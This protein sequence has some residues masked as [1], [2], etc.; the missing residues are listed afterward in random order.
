MPAPIPLHNPCTAAHLHSGADDVVVG[1]LGSE[2]VPAG[3]TVGSQNQG[4]LILWVKQLLD[5]AGPQPPSRS[6]LG[7]L[8]STVADRE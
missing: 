3:L 1:V 5:E 8:M 4:P 2:G 7:H 6:E